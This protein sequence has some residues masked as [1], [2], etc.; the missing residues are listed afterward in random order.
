[1][2][3]KVFSL[4]LLEVFLIIGFNYEDV[5]CFATTDFLDV[6]ASHMYYEDIT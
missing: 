3:K 1:M 5:K 6:P 2:F 4:F